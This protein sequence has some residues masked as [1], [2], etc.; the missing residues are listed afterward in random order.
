MAFPPSFLVNQL[1]DLMA[2]QRREV[3]PKCSSHVSQE[4][5]YCESC[6]FVFCSQCT[7]GKHGNPINNN[8]IVCEHTVIPFSIAIKRMS[9]ILLYKGQQCIGKL[10][11]SAQNVLN[12]MQKL[13]QNS[14]LAFEDINRTFQEI[15]NIVDKRRQELLNNVKKTREDKRS[16]L[17]EQLNTIE[18]EK[19]KL[20]S[21]CSGFKYQVE[22]R[23]I[24]KKINDLKDKLDSI[25]T[26]LDPKENCFLRFE[27]LH[28]SAIDNIQECVNNFG[29][30]RTSNT[31]PSLCVA[32][33]GKCSAHL[34]S[35]A[36]VVTYDYNGQ[37]QKF[38]GDPIS[39]NLLNTS[40]G[41]SIPCKVN[42]NRDG[43]YEIQFMP[44][45]SGTYSMKI[46]I[47]GRQVKNYPLE[48]EVSEHI[49]PLCIYGCKGSDQ[50]QFLQPTSLAIDDQDGHVYVLDTGNGRIKKLLQNQC[51]NS[52]FR[53]IG[54]IEGDGLENRAATGIAH[55]K[56]SHSLLVSNWRNRDVK[57]FSCDGQ[58]IRKFSHPELIEPTCIAVS[59][60]GM[61]MVSDNGANS[62][63]VFH[64]DGKLS[65]KING[66]AKQNALG[67]IGG[68]C[69]HPVSQDI[70]VAD[71]RI[72]VYSSSTGLFQKE[73][74]SENKTKGQYCGVTIDNN[75]NLLATRVDKYRSAIQV[76]DFDSGNLKFIIDS[77]DAKLK[78]PSC[79]ATTNDDHVIIVDLGND[80]I[81]KYR[82]F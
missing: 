66:K 39:V 34:R 49:N 16:I 56:Q 74:Y 70:I 1:L 35:F 14:E 43:T 32:T 22:V 53:V 13:D 44:L 11:E 5:L 46:D 58:F 7:G 50:H 8:G 38:G 63:F 29:S 75:G 72:L 54:H 68:I 62:V 41:Q 64:P 12:E 71:T 48:F 6:D 78:R 24:S 40:S 55:C 60:T 19:S 45:N 77:N 67:V 18:L 81:K 21:E 9:E 76:I 33:V 80:C 10:N 69:F 31:F 26:M 23:N 51:N 59:S 57:Q 42:D 61:I 17:R 73:L 79:L 47:F 15:I 28:N 30:V 2:S 27:H 3:V 4:L 82:Y 36:Y 52:P 25:N 65:L 20:E 37:R